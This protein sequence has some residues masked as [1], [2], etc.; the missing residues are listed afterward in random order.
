MIKQ[1]KLFKKYKRISSDDT[2]IIDQMHAGHDDGI[3]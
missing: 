1:Y 2:K 3:Q